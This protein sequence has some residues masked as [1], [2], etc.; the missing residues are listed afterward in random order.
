MGLE[1]ISIRIP[2]AIHDFRYA[3]AHNFM[4]RAVYPPEAR[5]LLRPKTAERLAKVA[6]RLRTEDGTRLLLYDCYRP[7][8]VQRLMW[9]VYPVRGYVAPPSSGS[10]HNRG[11]AVDLS[12][13]DEDG[14]PLPMPTDFDEFSE[15]AWPSYEGAS[16][17]QT[18]NRDRL[19]AAML[20]EGFTG[21]R[22][23]WWHYED[24]AERRAP[25]LDQPFVQDAPP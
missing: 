22:K 3:T 23:E 10:I 16:P 6:E 7:L 24:P 8:N 21:I 13:A 5:C 20:A 9:E 12:L 14:N 1:P 15:R 18:K 17:E 4:K 25:L 11:A 2:D 19:R